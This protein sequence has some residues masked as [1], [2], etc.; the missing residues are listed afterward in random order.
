MPPRHRLTC[1]GPGHSTSTIL[2]SNGSVDAME[3]VDRRA[4]VTTSR[5]RA[6]VPAVAS[7]AGVGRRTVSTG[8]GQPTS[9]HLRGH[10]VT[11]GQQLGKVVER[12]PACAAR[13]DVASLRPLCNQ[14]TSWP[15]PTRHAATAAPIAQ[16]GA[17][18]P[19]ARRSL[20]DERRGSRTDTTAKEGKTGVLGAR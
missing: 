18:R 4:D 5:R 1:A 19:Y 11:V 2:R 16:D 14:P 17:R 12:S 7:A 20:A 15:R 13:R 8:M 9:K 10:N 3:A 6:P